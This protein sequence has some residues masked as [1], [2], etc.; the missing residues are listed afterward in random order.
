MSRIDTV[1]SLFDG[2][3]REC[4]RETRSLTLRR[5]TKTDKRHY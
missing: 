1:T 4:S 3:D 2:I 5:Y